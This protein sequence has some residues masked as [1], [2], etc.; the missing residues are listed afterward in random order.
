LPF[1][2]VLAKDGIPGVENYVEALERDFRHALFLTGCRNVEA[3]KNTS[4]IL[5]ARL[6]EWVDQRKLG[7]W[8]V[9]NIQTPRTNRVR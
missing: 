5:G 1:L 8:P 2:R 3:L 9:S 7:G 6:K 4:I